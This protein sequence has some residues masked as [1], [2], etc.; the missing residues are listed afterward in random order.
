MLNNFNTCLTFTLSQEGGWSDN[1]AD[2]GG[3]TMDGV[4][5]AVYREWKN[6]SALDGDD[7]KSI[8]QSDIFSIYKQNYWD[9]IQG[10][11]LNSGVDLS[12]FD[13]DVNA[14]AHSAMI[15]QATIGV[16]VDGDIGPITLAAANAIDPM[17]LINELASNQ[18]KFYRSLSTFNVFGRGWLN[19][20]TARQIASL[21][22]V[23]KLTTMVKVRSFPPDDFYENI[24]SI[25]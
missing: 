11:S 18:A 7:L 4:T 24:K 3:D 16:T 1:P 19:R 9:V 17:T 25:A 12:V 6:D 14:G 10:D 23:N 5:L 20:V 22:L 2:P 21:G 8:S 13:M 15:L